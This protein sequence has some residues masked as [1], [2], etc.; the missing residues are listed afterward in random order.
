MTLSKQFINNNLW[1]PITLQK[2]GNK[3]LGY[4]FICCKD[5]WGLLFLKFL[6]LYKPSSHIVEWI[7]TFEVAN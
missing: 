3:A 7:Y 5:I 4:K 2:W 1:I 6:L